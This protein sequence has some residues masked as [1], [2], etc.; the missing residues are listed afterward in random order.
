MFVLR[1]SCLTKHS[2]TPSLHRPP[3][4]PGSQ[5]DLPAL[6][7]LVGAHLSSRRPELRPLPALP[8]SRFIIGAECHFQLTTIHSVLF[9]E[10]VRRG[11]QIPRRC[12]CSGSVMCTSLWSLVTTHE[13]LIVPLGNEACG[14]INIQ[15]AVSNGASFLCR[16]ST[17]GQDGRIFSR[18]QI[19]TLQQQDSLN[20]GM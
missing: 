1:F 12:C 5:I 11:R 15:I 6:G 13:C 9:Q 4:L 8:S 17:R 7:L 16:C 14:Q 2:R 10:S 18:S 19:A 20:Q 3:L